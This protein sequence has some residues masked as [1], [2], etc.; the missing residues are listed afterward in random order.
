MVWCGVKFYFVLMVWIDY[1]TL[2]H[3]VLDNRQVYDKQHLL[4]KQSFIGSPISDYNDTY[5]ILYS[6]CIIPNNYSCSIQ[7]PITQY[8][9]LCGNSWKLSALLILICLQIIYNHLQNLFDKIIV[10]Q[11]DFYIFNHVIFI[12]P[13]QKAGQVYIYIIGN[14]CH[15]RQTCSITVSTKIF[16]LCPQNH[17]FP[18]QFP[19]LSQINTFC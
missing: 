9:I 7:Y 5:N 10:F 1:P 12:P 6:L 4:C 19:T 11:I 2:L 18:K 3:N 17:H 13:D 14:N 16:R 15:F 8:H